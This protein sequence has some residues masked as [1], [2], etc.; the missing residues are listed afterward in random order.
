LLQERQIFE[1]ETY[2]DENLITHLK[3]E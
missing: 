2:C 3:G 1:T